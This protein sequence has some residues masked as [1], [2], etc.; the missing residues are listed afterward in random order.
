MNLVDNILQKASHKYFT[1]V[2]FFLTVCESIFLFIPPEVF[3]TPPIVADKKRAL[4]VTIAAVLG[5]VVGGAIAYM[6][7]MWLFSS[8][9]M[10]L[11]TNFASMEK[12]EVAQQ[13]FHQHG[14]FILFIAAFT[15]APYKLIAL[16][17]GFMHFPII[18]FLGLTTLFRTGRFAIAGFLLWKFQEKANRM[19]KKYFWPITI[20]AVLISIFGLSLLL[21]I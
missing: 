4:P 10:W 18:I 15:P 6:I 19:V 16:C 2:V 7:G 9:G 21:L 14:V 13:M 11:I 1:W 12:F 3:M 5:S 17:A 20:G 8:V